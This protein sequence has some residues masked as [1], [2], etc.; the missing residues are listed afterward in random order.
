MRRGV[1][2][3]I[4][5]F[6]IALSVLFSPHC[7]IFSPDEEKTFNFP[8]YYP[9]DAN[10][11]WYYSD[12]TAVSVAGEPKSINNEPA[13]V[14][15][16]TFAKEPPRTEYISA[17]GNSIRILAADNLTYQPPMRLAN[18]TVKIGE[19][20]ADSVK[21]IDVTGK[22]VLEF[23][24][25]TEFL[26]HTDVVDCG[27]GKFTNCLKLRAVVQNARVGLN[28]TSYS[29]FAK[30]IGNVKSGSPGQFN[31]STLDSANLRGVKYP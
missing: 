23:K 5:F 10:N 2:I 12:N 31:F 17:S 20:L 15:K 11:V 4:I 26:S 21:I 24:V 1:S 29:W 9:L 28:D 22:T 7:G 27:A 14:V 18:K 8:D 3:L 19:V 6:V 13:T 30:N 16:Y 25:T